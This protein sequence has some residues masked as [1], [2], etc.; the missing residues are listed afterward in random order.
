MQ[1]GNRRLFVWVEKEDT[2]VS[3][4]Q[5]TERVSRQGVKVSGA[6][7][8]IKLTLEATPDKYTDALTKQ[9]QL[10]RECELLIESAKRIGARASFPE[11]PAPK[12]TKGIDIAIG[13]IILTAITTETISLLFQYIKRRI[14]SGLQKDYVYGVDIKKGGKRKTLKLR[15]SNFSEKEISKIIESIKESIG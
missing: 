7:T 15:A 10:T 3:H 6:E 4:W 14:D 13:A 5:E 9:D 11:V 12:D 8:E 2:D 1:S